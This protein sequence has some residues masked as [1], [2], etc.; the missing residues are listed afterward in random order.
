[1]MTTLLAE[2]L[3]T[4]TLS[5]PHC[6][7]YSGLPP[8]KHNWW[9][10]IYVM[11]SL[12]K[13]KETTSGWHSSP[14]I[15]FAA[16]CSPPLHKMPC[17]FW[18]SCLCTCCSL[19]PG[20]LP[21]LHCLR[22]IISF[23]EMELIYHVPLLF[24]FLTFTSL[25]RVVSPS[26]LT[27]IYHRTYQPVSQVADLHAYFPP[28]LWALQGPGPRLKRPCIYSI[29]WR[30]LS[31]TYRMNEWYLSLVFSLL[32][33]ASFMLDLTLT[34]RWTWDNSDKKQT[35]RVL[36]KPQ[37]LI[38]V[39]FCTQRAS[40]PRAHHMLAQLVRTAQVSAH[41]SKVHTHQSTPRAQPPP[42]SPRSKPISKSWADVI[43]KMPIIQKKKSR[44][45]LQCRLKKKK[46][47]QGGKGGVTSQWERK[48]LAPN[49][50]GS[51]WATGGHWVAPHHSTG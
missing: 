34:K 27:Y 17:F 22:N 20:C 39:A 41:K 33:S 1:M 21:W 44:N 4:L 16:F 8:P 25:D 42:K 2:W 51:H 37:W 15:P 29:Q 3:S 13:N 49:G 19:H 36:S 46:T 9:C 47:T 14:T 10:F 50:W 32:S 11:A 18:T 26:T 40:P 35:F 45:T 6:L 12:T 31:M 7:P 28:A 24:F 30:A 5:P 48:D 38:S 43:I 23:S